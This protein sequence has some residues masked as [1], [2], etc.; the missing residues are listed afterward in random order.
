MAK[1]MSRP[2]SL[3]EDVLSAPVSGDSVI[4]HKKIPFLFQSPALTPSHS[5]R[6]PQ[7]CQVAC[8]KH[9]YLILEGAGERQGGWDEV[10]E[11]RQLQ[12]C[13]RG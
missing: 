11:S 8:L 2:V 1:N 13:F 9:Q 3:N 6:H 4:R 7:P 12:N 10:E 5:H